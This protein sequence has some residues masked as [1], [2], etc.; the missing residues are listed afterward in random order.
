MGSSRGL[1]WSD[2]TGGSEAAEDSE[3]A[4]SDGTGESEDVEGLEDALGFRPRFGRDPSSA[5]GRR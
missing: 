1:C 4:W 2:G 5:S 3:D